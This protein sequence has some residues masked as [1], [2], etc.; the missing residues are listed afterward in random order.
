MERAKALF[1]TLAAG[2]S[3]FG[4]ATTL[5]KC[6]NWSCTSSIGLIV[7]I[8]RISVGLSLVGVCSDWSFT[9]CNGRK[10]SSG[11]F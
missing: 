6:G 2:M 8:I 11:G 4:E 5:E 9:F 1:D 7:S 3:S 10:V